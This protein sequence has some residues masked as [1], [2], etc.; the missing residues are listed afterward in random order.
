M[1][2]NNSSKKCSQRESLLSFYLFELSFFALCFIFLSYWN[3]KQTLKTLDK[4]AAGM[5]NGLSQRIHRE[6]EHFVSN[7][8]KCTVIYLCP[9]VFFESFRRDLNE[10][11]AVSCKVVNYLI[12]SVNI[13]HLPLCN[14]DAPI[15]SQ[16]SSIATAVMYGGPQ[17]TPLSQRENTA[18]KKNSLQT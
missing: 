4:N 11:K 10:A 8:Y 3:S 18:N 7:K 9:C 5:L 14:Y 2:R 15:T 6:P 13:S 12:S 17:G 16:V 1:K